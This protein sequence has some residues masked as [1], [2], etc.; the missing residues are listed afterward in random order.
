M[1]EIL[2]YNGK[3]YRL[4]YRKC[5]KK[6]CATCSD[7]P[8]HGPY[9]YATDNKTKKREYIG[10]ELPPDAQ[11]AANIQSN[12]YRVYKDL[13]DLFRS[14]KRLKTGAELDQHDV[15]VLAQVGIELTGDF[16]EPESFMSVLR[17]VFGTQSAS[18]ISVVNGDETAQWALKGGPRPW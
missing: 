17:H 14:V 1:M 5:G 4:Q 11:Q 18:D 3:T 13:E 8:G 10:K 7:G 12:L 16:P 2:R 6:G 15:E 9:W